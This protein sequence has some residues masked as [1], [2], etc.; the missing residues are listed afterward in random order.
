MTPQWVSGGTGFCYIF[1][2][3]CNLRIML[4][5][6]ILNENFSLNLHEFKQELSQ[7]K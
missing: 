7:G 6:E 2:V 4:E 3:V 1:L 5:A